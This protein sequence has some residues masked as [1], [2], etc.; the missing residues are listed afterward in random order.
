MKH[1]LGIASAIA[2]SAAVTVGAAFCAYKKW[3]KKNV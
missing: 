3:G 1:P 2:I